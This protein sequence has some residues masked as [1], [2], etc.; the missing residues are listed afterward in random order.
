[1]TQTSL[2]YQKECAALKAQ[3]AASEKENAFH[4]NLLNNI[5]GMIFV[6]ENYYENSKY[7]VRLVY[8]ND[9]AHDVTGHS[10]EDCAI[11]DVEFAKTLMHPIDYAIS[12][13]SFDFFKP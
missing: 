13:K 2:K 1:M 3:L 5:P 8:S 11:L 6:T 7:C 10:R 12:E 9:F 4:K